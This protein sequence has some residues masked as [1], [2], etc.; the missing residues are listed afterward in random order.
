MAE[1]LALNPGHLNATRNLQWLRALGRAPNL[2][3]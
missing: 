2:A 3:R 1:T